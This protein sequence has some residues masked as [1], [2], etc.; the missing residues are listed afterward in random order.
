MKSLVKISNIAFWVIYLGV[1][2]QVFAQSF[3]H[4]FG[5]GKIEVNGLYKVLLSPEFCAIAQ[6]NFTDVRLSSQ[7]DSLVEVPYFIRNEEEDSSKWN[8]CRFTFESGGTRKEWCKSLMVSK[9]EL[10]HEKISQILIYA[11]QKYGLNQIQ[12]VIQSP[13]YFSRE[14]IVYTKAL[15]PKRRLKGGIQKN[16]LERFQIKKGESLSFT[17]NHII[18]DT[19]YLDILNLN[20]PP[21]DIAE[22]VIKQ[23]PKV[24]YAYLNKGDLAT[25][26]CGNSTLQ[27][28]CYDLDQF[29]NEIVREPIKELKIGEGKLIVNVGHSK[30]SLNFWQTKEF[31]WIC[32]IIAI[33]ITAYFSWALLKEKKA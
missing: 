33:I 23:S 7:A 27:F 10:P 19:L 16:I 11:R 30:G 32:L 20:N 22:L 14:V 18:T 4:Q 12:F 13:V 25:L 28:P 17:I 31:L 9:R 2:Q 3:T 6:D 8:V 5:L 26:F 29:S 24:L 21:L 1:L 15:Q